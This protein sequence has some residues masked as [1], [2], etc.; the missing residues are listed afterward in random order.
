MVPTN[1]STKWLTGQVISTKLFL[2]KPAKSCPDVKKHLN[3]NNVSADYADYVTYR[4]SQLNSRMNA[5]GA[6]LLREHCGLSVVRWRLIALLAGSSGPV[7]SSQL[8]STIEMDPGQFSR[9]LKALIEDGL[10]ISQ[11]DKTDNRQHVLTLSRQG[12]ARFNK[13][14]PVMKERRESIMNGLSST[15]KKHFFRTLDRIENNLKA[16]LLN[17]SHA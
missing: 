3:P 11:L 5:Q 8:A 17:K 12:R 10:I 1:N 7:T 4:I 6:R 9:N 14:E 15:D 13:A 2:M 16:E